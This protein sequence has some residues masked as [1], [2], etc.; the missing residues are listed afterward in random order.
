MGARHAL[1]P[2]HTLGALAFAGRVLPDATFRGMRTFRSHGGTVPAVAGRNLSSE[3]STPGSVAPCRGPH[4]GRGADV[5]AKSVHILTVIT[6]TTPVFDRLLAPCDG[7]DLLSRRLHF[8]LPRGDV[9]FHIA[10]IE[11]VDE[12]C[13]VRSL[14]AGTP[15]LRIRLVKSG[16]FGGVGPPTMRQRPGRAVATVNPSG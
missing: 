10:S 4:A 1:L 9:F 11:E 7:S 3:A 2:A 6:G 5:P 12:L 16:P 13:Q 8:V 15:L 14:P